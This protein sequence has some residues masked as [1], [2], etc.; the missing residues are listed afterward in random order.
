MVLLI[1]SINDWRGRI[2]QYVC[3]FRFL[4][5]VFPGYHRS[6]FVER[7]KGADMTENRNYLMVVLAR[8]VKVLRKPP[9]FVG[10]VTVIALVVNCSD[11]PLF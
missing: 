4:L 5:L 1:F 6:V 3:I 8:L 2:C 10:L 7:V 9:G 11:R